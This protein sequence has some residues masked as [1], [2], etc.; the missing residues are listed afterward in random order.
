VPYLDAKGAYDDFYTDDVSYLIGLVHTPLKQ[1]GDEIVVLAQVLA[2]ETNLGYEHLTDLH[3]LKFNGIEVRSLGHL[4]KLISESEEPFMTFEFAPGEGG[5][6]IVMERAVCEQAT[7][8]VC[9]EHSIGSHYVLRTD[10]VT[11]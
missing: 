3:L 2:H 10:T 8:E 6:L 5:R 1:H 4:N 11:M 9:K 7:Q